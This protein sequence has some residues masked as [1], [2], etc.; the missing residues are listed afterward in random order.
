MKLNDKKLRCKAFYANCIDRISAADY[1]NEWVENTDK[2]TIIKQ[3]D[4]IT[5]G[6]Y[7]TTT[8]VVYFYEIK[9]TTTVS[10]AEEE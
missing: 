7:H 5:T 6:Q 1:F 3:I 4:T 2:D 9:N 8:I 10:F